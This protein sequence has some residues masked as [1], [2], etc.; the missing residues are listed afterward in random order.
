MTWGG[1]AGPLIKPLA[2]VV[3][4]FLA[5]CLQ[6]GGLEV[7]RLGKRLGQAREGVPQQGGLG[8]LG[9]DLPGSLLDQ[10][11]PVGMGDSLKMS[12]YLF[13]GRR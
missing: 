13:G 4:G 9:C 8:G 12:G 10:N 3:L 2:P 11:G 1:N 5:P 7:G 6:A